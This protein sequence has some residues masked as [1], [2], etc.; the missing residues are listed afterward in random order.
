[1]DP[2]ISELSNGKV[3]F[4]THGPSHLCHA[5]VLHICEGHLREGGFYSVSLFYFTILLLAWRINCYRFEILTCHGIPGFILQPM[6]CYFILGNLKVL[7]I[8]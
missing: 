8:L 3:S 5:S 2:M 4:L 1:M 7:Q 6:L